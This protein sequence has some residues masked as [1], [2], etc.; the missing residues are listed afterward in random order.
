MYEDLLIA[1]LEHTVNNMD[2]GE[3]EGTE[4]QVRF[5]GRCSGQRR[6]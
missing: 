6:S 3:D 1:D 4:N 5:M 2:V